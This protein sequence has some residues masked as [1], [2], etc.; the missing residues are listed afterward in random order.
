MAVAEVKDY[1]KLLPHLKEAPERTV[2]LSYDSDGDVLYINYKKPSIATDSELTDE[3]I[4][5]RCD[6]DEIIGLTVLHA[7]N[8]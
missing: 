3:D 2:W 8:R 7:S 4:I 1:L 5:V 6:G